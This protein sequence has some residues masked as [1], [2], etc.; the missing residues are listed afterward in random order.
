MAQ[1]KLL[2]NTLDQSSKLKNM[3][4]ERLGC[5]PKSFSGQILYGQCLAFRKLL[6]RTLCSS[7]LSSEVFEWY[8]MGSLHKNI[9]LMLEFLKALFLVL[10]FLLYIIDLPDNVCEIAIYA[11]DTTVRYYASDLRQR[12]KLASELESD[13]RNT[14]DRGRKCLVDFNNGK[15]QLVLFHQSSNCGAV[16]VKING[17]LF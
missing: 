9:Q 2:Q 3:S 17:F 10:Q 6:F 4:D 1:P 11:D 13:L 15:T 16:D 8:F 12:L 7:T 14:G 5:Q